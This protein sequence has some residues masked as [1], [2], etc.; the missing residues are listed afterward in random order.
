MM[1]TTTDWIVFV[2]C[3]G[4]VYP[5]ADDY[6]AVPGGDYGVGWAVISAESSKEAL[7]RAARWSEGTDDVPMGMC[8]EALARQKLAARATEH[9]AAAHAEWGSDLAHRDAELRRNVREKLIAGGLL[10]KPSHQE[11]EAIQNQRAQ[12]R[13]V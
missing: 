8:S 12:W 7:R 1:N 9:A 2:E 11:P 4:S 5:M 10:K 6:G 3:G 13:S